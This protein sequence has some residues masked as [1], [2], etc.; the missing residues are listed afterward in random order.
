MHKIIHYLIHHNTGFSLPA[1]RRAGDDGGL[2]NPRNS[3]SSHSSVAELRL[4]SRAK[5]KSETPFTL[6]TYTSEQT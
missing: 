5:A 3:K 2:R 1:A 6:T 4:E